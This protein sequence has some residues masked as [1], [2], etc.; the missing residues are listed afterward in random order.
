[1]INEGL[2]KLVFGSFLNG[3][4]MEW[5]KVSNK[6]RCFTG[7]VKL[8]NNGELALDINNVKN[9]NNNLESDKNFFSFNA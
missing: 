9:S 6:H 4:F 1:M 2:N 3:N 7:R 8:N 5:A